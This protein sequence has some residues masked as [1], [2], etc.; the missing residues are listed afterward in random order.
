MQ[1]CFWHLQ[2]VKGILRFTSSYI[3]TFPMKLRSKSIDYAHDDDVIKMKSP[4]LLSFSHGQVIYSNLATVAT[5]IFWSWAAKVTLCSP[6][7]AWDDS[8]RTMMVNQANFVDKLSSNY[9]HNITR[10][11]AT[12]TLRSLSRLSLRRSVQSVTVYI[13]VSVFVHQ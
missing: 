7:T 5:V 4:C 12:V 8:S 11:R 6:S 9:F 13:E 1:C 3:C 2:Y 10:W